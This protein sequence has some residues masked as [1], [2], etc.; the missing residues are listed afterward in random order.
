MITSDQSDMCIVDQEQIFVLKKPLIGK[1]II[2]TY[3]GWET[4]RITKHYFDI[5]HTQTHLSHPLLFFN[6]TISVFFE[7]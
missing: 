3:G 2:V 1:I 7:K 4:S 6:I 5:L